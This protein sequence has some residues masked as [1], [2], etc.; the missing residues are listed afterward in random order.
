MRRLDPR[1]APKCEGSGG[2]YEVSGE[3]VR[4]AVGVR[5]RTLDCPT[6]K[7]V[8]QTVAA[9]PT[10]RGRPCASLLKGPPVGRC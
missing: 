1:R 9:I 8:S 7:L 6:L 10:L 3:C 2:Y 5:H 4:G